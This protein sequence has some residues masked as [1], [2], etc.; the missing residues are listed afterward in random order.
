MKWPTDIAGVE[1]DTYHRWMDDRRNL[2][3]RPVAAMPAGF[4]AI[5]LPA[6]V[7]FVGPPCGDRTTLEFALAYERAQALRGGGN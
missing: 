4:R 6:G 7:Q 3:G 2:A 5:G 1:M